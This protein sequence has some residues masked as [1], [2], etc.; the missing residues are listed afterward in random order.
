MANS[1]IH[2]SAVIGEEVQIADNVTIGPFC[3]IE[4]KVKIG[5]GTI[6]HSHC[7]LKGNLEIGKIISSFQFTSIESSARPIL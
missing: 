6:L 1:N 7:V 5:K 4:G 2:P 3:L